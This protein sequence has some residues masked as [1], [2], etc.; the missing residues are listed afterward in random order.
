MLCLRIT[1]QLTYCG[2][3]LWTTKRYT[4]R[5]H[6]LLPPAPNKTLSDRSFPKLEMEYY[7]L[8]NSVV[9]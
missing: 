1:I 9:I 5:E 6:S 8:K 3:L 7:L 4:S 2:S